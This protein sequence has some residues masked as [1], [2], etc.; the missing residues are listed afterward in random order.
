MSQNFS[1]AGVT[2][3][4]VARAIPTASTSRRAGEWAVEQAFASHEF[5]DGGRQSNSAS[6]VPRLPG[7]FFQPKELRVAGSG[8]GHHKLRAEHRGVTGDV[9]PVGG[10]VQIGRPLQREAG[11]VCRPRNEDL[12]IGFGRAQ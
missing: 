7:S 11:I 9:R 4:F 8:I 12:V 3:P 1:P 5:E 10:R 6:S 2:S